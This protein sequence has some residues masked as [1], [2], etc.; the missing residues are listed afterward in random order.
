[1]IHLS[2]LSVRSERNPHGD[3]NIEFSGLRPGEKLFEELLIGDNVIAT[4]HPMI[5][6]AQEDC[7]PWD[8]MKQRLTALLA[9]ID[10]DDY[11]TIRQILRETVAGY[12]PQGEIVDFIHLQRRLEP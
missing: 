11:V 9:A 5:M 6:S 10:T 2:G 4:R 3:I 7:L 8:I 1:M 12:A